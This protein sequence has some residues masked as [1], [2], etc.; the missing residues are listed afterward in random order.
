MHTWFIYLLPVFPVF[1]WDWQPTCM[2]LKSFS[3]PPGCVLW[4]TN[5]SRGWKEVALCLI[6]TCFM[7][8]NFTLPTRSSSPP[9]I[10][11]FLKKQLHSRPETFQIHLYCLLWIWKSKCK[12]LEPD[13]YS[14]HFVFL[15]CF[16]ENRNLW[17]Y[18]AE[19]GSW[20]VSER[21]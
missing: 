1:F 17:T 19:W 7:N 18:A 8:S 4:I 13:I 21:V 5:L 3:S 2:M 9:N 15:V 20:A 6:T 14:I 16:P 11:S 12:T 10:F